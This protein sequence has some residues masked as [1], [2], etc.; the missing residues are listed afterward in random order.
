MVDYY[1]IKKDNT[2]IDDIK[3]SIFLTGSPIHDNILY[4]I[5]L[6]EIP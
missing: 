1:N 2:T 4:D 5:D 3:K 6:D